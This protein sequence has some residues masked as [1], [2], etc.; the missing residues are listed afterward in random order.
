M[1]TLLSHATDP[2]AHDD[3]W[4]A[5]LPPVSVMAEVRRTLDAAASSAQAL[6]RPIVASVT[7]PLDATSTVPDPIAAF[8]AR[9]MLDLD[10]GFY[11]EQP[12]IGRAL[13]GLGVAAQITTDGAQSVADAA[14]ARATLLRDAVVSVSAGAS[15]A[16]AQPVLLG[17]FAFDS[18]RPSTPRWQSFPGGQLVL[19]EVLLSYDRSGTTLTLNARIEPSAGTRQE[20]SV[21][22][23]VGR[24]MQHLRTLSDLGASAPISTPPQTRATQSAS[25]LQLRELRPADAWMALVDETRAAIAAGAYAKVVLA[26]GVEAEASAPFDLGATLAHLR[27]SYPSAY[28]FAV[29]QGQ[30]CF[31]GATPEQLAQVQHG[32]LATMALAGSAPR[33]TDAAADAAL[34]AG[35]MQSAKNRQEHAIVVETLR[36]LLAPLSTEL[37]IP[38]SPHLLALANV[39]HLETPI[40]GALRPGASILDVVAVLHPTPAVCGLPRQA[41]LE[42]LRARE[43]LDRGWYAGPVGW[44]GADGDGEF[45]VALRSALVTGARATLF[46]GCGIVADS[47][48]QTEY[49]ESRLKL[50]VMLRGLSGEE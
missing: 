6:R 49:D 40:R 7:L 41:A 45:A 20:L 24:L 5:S 1:S 46:A 14:S 2:R 34:G 39:Q 32:H 38:P 21:A 35:L 30:S 16:L 42:V 37:T 36:D 13:V 9:T 4:F 23:Q 19:P 47:N 3:R 18:L 44:V 22:R 28:I 27:A 17:G 15:P 12:S 33:G 31:L 8:T 48:P 10:Q 11:W 43:S 26:R 29:Q 50:Q 25:T